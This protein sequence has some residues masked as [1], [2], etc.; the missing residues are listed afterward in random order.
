MSSFDTGFRTGWQHGRAFEE[1]ERALLAELQRPFVGNDPKLLAPVKVLVRRPFYV[2][3]KEMKVGEEI[4]LSR[5][6]AD[7]L[8]AIGKVQILE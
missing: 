8:R 5:H 1:I 2:A 6:D 7:S 4:K 3:G